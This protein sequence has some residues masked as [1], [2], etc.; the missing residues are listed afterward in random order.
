MCG[1]AVVIREKQTNG[2]V[3]SYHVLPLPPKKKTHT[4]TFR[5]THDHTFS[6]AHLV[7]GK[8]TMD[9]GNH[10]GGDVVAGKDK[11]VP[12]VQDVSE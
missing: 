6:L 2:G 12:V 7:K 5:F 9:G 1:C 3:Y 4:H 11:V 8:T 10:I